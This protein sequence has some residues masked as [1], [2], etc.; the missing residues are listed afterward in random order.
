MSYQQP[1]LMDVDPN[2]QED[3]LSTTSSS[4]AL[5]R[6]TLLRTFRDISRQRVA[7]RQQ[8]FA[9]APSAEPTPTPQDDWRK[10]AARILRFLG[11]FSRDLQ[12]TKY[13]QH[14]AFRIMSNIGQEFVAELE[15][16]ANRILKGEEI[17]GEELDMLNNALGS[18]MEE[19]SRLQ[20]EARARNKAQHQAPHKR[21]N[22]HEE[23]ST[24]MQADLGQTTMEMRT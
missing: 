5:R 20:A 6:S 3:E 1:L 10:K 18:W 2:S 24:Q 19:V 8:P 22:I 14:M 21:A 7:S 17:V 12:D 16:Q 23:V 13:A 11:Y 15:R 9:R 4:H